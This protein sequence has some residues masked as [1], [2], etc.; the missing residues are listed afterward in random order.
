MAVAKRTRHDPRREA[1]RAAL[2]EAAE[3]L[4]AEGG[5]EG[6]STRQIG[7]AI[8]SAN[9]NVVA[10]HFGSKEELIKA[11][12]RHRL[13]EIDRRRR[14]LLDEADAAGTSGDIAVLVRIFFQPFL[15][16]TDSQGRHSY[17]RFVAGMERSGLAALRGQLLDEFPE[18]NRLNDR[19]AALL[20]QG[21]LT[22]YRLRQRLAVGLMST[23]FLLIDRETAGDA[24]LA[25]R[26][27]ETAIAMAAAAMA[28]P[29]PANPD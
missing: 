5:V 3:S 2:I 22:D 12:Y 8:G 21:S 20:P 19:M 13:P 23:A 7:A 15:E 1:T 14:E 28:A 26:H 25:Q 9:A 27:F 16:Q 24:A 11:V 18:T 10:Y 4:F 17:A 29:L 6:V